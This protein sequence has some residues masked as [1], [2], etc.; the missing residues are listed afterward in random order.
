MVTVG[1]MEDPI[2]TC[3]Y[4][5]E[6][7]KFWF[8]R[9]PLMHYKPYRIDYGDVVETGMKWDQE[10]A[11]REHE[12]RINTS[13]AHIMDYFTAHEAYVLSG[14]V[15]QYPQLW[16]RKVIEGVDPVIEKTNDSA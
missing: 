4:R 11:D 13:P 2:A 12:S 8:R 1:V 6:F 15:I 7:S 16:G 9:L 3:N 14:A 10:A 5:R